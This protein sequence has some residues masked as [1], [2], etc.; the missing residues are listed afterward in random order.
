MAKETPVSGDDG[1]DSTSAIATRVARQV[2]EGA[3]AVTTALGVVL[4]GVALIADRTIPTSWAVAVVAV[5]A[6]ASLANVWLAIRRRSQSGWR[7]HWGGMAEKAW[8]DVV[9]ARRGS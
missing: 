3:A 7:Q 1:M 8:G 6:L 5:T 2:S 4:S 9:N